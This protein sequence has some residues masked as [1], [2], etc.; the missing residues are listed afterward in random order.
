MDADSF[1]MDL[2]KGHQREENL[3]GFPSVMVSVF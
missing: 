3:I 2:S 1:S